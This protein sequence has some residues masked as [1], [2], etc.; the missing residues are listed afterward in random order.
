MEARLSCPY[1]EKCGGCRYTNETYAESV[2]KKE[3][4]VCTM[5]SP[6]PVEPIV[7]MEDPFHYRN[8]VHH[9]LFK[10]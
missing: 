7:R 5:L 1:A 2:L 9:V 10:R 4:A 3:A 8:K 6:W